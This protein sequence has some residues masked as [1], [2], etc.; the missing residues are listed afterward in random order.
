[1]TT[2][3]ARNIRLGAGSSPKTGW[4]LCAVAAVVVL[5]VGLQFDEERKYLAEREHECRQREDRPGHQDR[6]QPLLRQAA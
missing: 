2:S 4:R 6:H 1:M 5:G 3:V